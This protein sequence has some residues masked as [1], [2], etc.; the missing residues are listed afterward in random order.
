MTLAVSIKPVSESDEIITIANL[1][2][3]IWNDHFVDIIGQ[4]QVDYMLKVFQ[5]PHAIAS[6]IESGYEYYLVLLDENQAGYLAIVTDSDKGKAMIS[7]IYIRREYRRK[8]LGNYL[9]DFVKKESGNRGLG[10]IWL[11]VNRHNHETIKWYK[12]NDFV[13]VDEV[14]KDIGGGFFMDDY[15]MELETG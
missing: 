11:T 2:G 4:A 8:G 9:L 13:V 1:A 7:K 10:L 14:K 12:R 5:S 3:E 15:I 6:Q